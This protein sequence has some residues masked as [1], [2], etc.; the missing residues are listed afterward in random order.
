[1]KVLTIIKKSMGTGFML[2]TTR[3]VNEKIIIGDDI[4][5]VVMK[6]HS[7]EVSLGIKAPRHI[8]I[9]CKKEENTVKNNA[10]AG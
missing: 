4:T 7:N 5:I 6:T 10:N 8:R 2:V 3:R 9:G 1:M